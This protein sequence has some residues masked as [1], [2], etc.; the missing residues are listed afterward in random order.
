MTIND[1]LMF[2]VYG[3]YAG[4]RW[5]N[6]YFYRLLSFVGT[7]VEGESE[8]L[9]AAWLNEYLSNIFTP[10]SSSFSTELA[11]RGVRGEN[12]FNVAVIGASELISPVLGTNG[13]EP[14]PPEQAYGWSTPSLRRGMNSGQRRMPGCVTE[15]VG[16]LGILTAPAVTVLN[17]QG[18]DMGADMVLSFG[19][20]IEDFTIRPV[21]VKRVREGEG[22]DEDPYT[23]RLPRTAGEAISYRANNWRT[24]PYVTT[25]N[26][27]KYG[28]GA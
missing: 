25:Q 24:K 3:T 11:V 12:L 23:Y 5:E 17:N 21:I 18:A 14:A 10:Y 15:L 9:M 7:F 28:R 1:I 26:S 13:T 27:R 22:T 19:S 2:I 20:T 16:N 4:Q 6:T 8:Q